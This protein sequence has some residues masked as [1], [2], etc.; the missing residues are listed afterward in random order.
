MSK[1]T[2]ASESLTAVASAIRDK[3]GKTEKIEFPNG[4]TDEIG[5]VYEAGK[6]A[7]YDAFWDAYQLNGTRTSYISAFSAMFTPDI[8]K[9]KYPVR[10]T[11]AY[12]MFFNNH[13]ETLIIPDFVKFCE[14]N[15]VVLD[16]SQCISADY[17][18][19]CLHSNRF[20][21][22]DFSKCTRTNYLFYS[23]AVSSGVVTIDEFISSDITKY[24]S[25]TFEQAT[26]LTNITFRGIIASNIWF[27][28]CNKLTHDSLMS[29]INALKDYSDDTSGTD[30]VVTL[31]STNIAKLTEEEIAIAENKGWRLE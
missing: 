9:P 28:N 19:A 1:L 21:V 8:F 23:H 11:R 17:A 22:L 6:K 24:S 16:F 2:V 18:L 10:P 31:G 20:G 5:E 29:I 14:E 30:W 25:G 13:G 15:N 7:E 12:Y 27:Q 26:Y 4:F 3:T